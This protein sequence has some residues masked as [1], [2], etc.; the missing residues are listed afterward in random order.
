MPIVF[1]T[2]TKPIIPIIPTEPIKP[3]EPIISEDDKRVEILD[4]LFAENKDI[5]DKKN[6]LK[7]KV[8]LLS[9]ENELLFYIFADEYHEKKAKNY[10]VTK[11][12]M[13]KFLNKFYEKANKYIEKI[14][15]KY[16]QKSI[17]LPQ[18]PPLQQSYDN[19][20]VGSN[21]SVKTQKSILLPPTPPLHSLYDN[22]SDV[23]NKSNPLH[24]IPVAPKKKRTK[25]C[26]SRRWI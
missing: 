3:I 11:E 1:K 17:L 23:S 7:E 5:D 10:T 19:K 9:R 26:R 2:F 20:S 18:T 13:T 21:K 24:N 15:L 25:S 4:L 22:I 12:G 6:Q 14:E 8:N 16:P